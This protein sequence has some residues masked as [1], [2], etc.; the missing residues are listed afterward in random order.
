MSASDA[1]PSVPEAAR[2]FAHSRA[3][4]LAFAAPVAVLYAFAVAGNGIRIAHQW[5][6]AVD[7]PSRFTIA[8]E[9]ATLLFFGLQACLFLVR[10]LPVAKSDGIWPRVAAVLG[11]NFNLTLLLLP[12]AT[13]GAAWTSVSF[14]LTMA[15]TIGS[16]AVLIRL[17]RAFAV[18]PEARDFV[19]TGPYRFARHPL[20]LAE[21]VSMLGIMLG[22]RQPWAIL[23]V[24]ATVA[25][26]LRRMAFEE[27]ILAQTYPAYDAYR[28]RTARLLPGV[29]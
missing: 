21:I 27:D 14:A 12:R 5:Q 19:R 18:F 29:Y 28:R 24:L 20:Y 1:P 7:M 25:L 13:L 17:G 4:D 8:N 11:A 10:R 23:I 15:G 22:F 6:N 3:Y 16:I 9:I 26:Q 2:A